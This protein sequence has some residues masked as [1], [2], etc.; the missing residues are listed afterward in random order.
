MKC[1]TTITAADY[2]NSGS[3]RDL[4]VASVALIERMGLFC[5][6]VPN[7][8]KRN[9]I[10]A[11]RMKAA[12]VRAGVTDLVVILP[13]GRVGWLELKD[14]AGKLSASQ[15]AFRNHLQAN[16]HHWA[17]CRT[18]DQVCEAVTSWKSAAEQEEQ[19]ASYRS[20]RS[21]RGDLT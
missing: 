17:E 15:C 11:T 10:E 18:L 20:G 19:S 9:V 8:G 2:R 4:Q 5:F 7:G 12:G 6:H 13:S 14:G 16:G 3:E 1:R 21:A